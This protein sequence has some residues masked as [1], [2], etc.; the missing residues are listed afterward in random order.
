VDYLYSCQFVRSCCHHLALP[1]LRAV[2]E[3]R[4]LI[5]SRIVPSFNAAFIFV[6]YYRQKW[7]MSE[8][9]GGFAI[10]G[11]ELGKTYF[12]GFSK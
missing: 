1:Y 7:A 2:N 10:L 9:L 8:P 3:L 11:D 6:G 5:Q 4:Y 12:I